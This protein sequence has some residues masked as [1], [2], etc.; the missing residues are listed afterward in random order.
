MRTRP[1]RLGAAARRGRLVVK[2]RPAR[3]GAAARRGRLIVVIHDRRLVVAVRHPTAKMSGARREQARGAPRRR[4]P[5]VPGGRCAA[6]RAEDTAISK[7]SAQTGNRAGWQE[8]SNSPNHSGDG[9]RIF[10]E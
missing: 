10:G 4:R 7:G 5:T 9:Q 8:S 6:G 1:A 2:T 3:L